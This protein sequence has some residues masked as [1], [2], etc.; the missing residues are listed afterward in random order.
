VPTTS[1]AVTLLIK[2]KASTKKYQTVSQ[3]ENAVSVL[4]LVTIAQ[5]F[6]K[7]DSKKTIQALTGE[8][9]YGKETMILHDQNAIAQ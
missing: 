2:T 1:A 7:E 8:A 3:T 9:N 6:A 5:T 4:Y